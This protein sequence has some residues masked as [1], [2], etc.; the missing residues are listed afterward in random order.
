M[1]NLLKTVLQK[2]IRKRQQNQ[3]HRLIQGL[4]ILQKSSIQHTVFSI[5]LVYNKS[6]SSHKIFNWNT[7]KVS[8]SCMENVRQIIRIRNNRVTKQ[9]KNPQHHVITRDK[10]NCPMKG[11]YRLENLVQKCFVSAAE[12]SNKHVYIVIAEGNGSSA[13]TMTSFL[14]GIRCKKMI[15]PVQNFSGSLRNQKKKSLSIHGQF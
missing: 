10:N 12:K 1:K 11:N 8:Y 9:T 3:K 2:H 15:Q 7:I 4:Q 6:N 13:T 14:L 5:F